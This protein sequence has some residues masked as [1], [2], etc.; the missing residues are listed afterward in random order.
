MKRSALFFAIFNLVALLCCGQDPPVIHAVTLQDTVVEQY[1]KLEAVVDLGATYTNPYDYDQIVVSA[2][3]TGPTGE[4]TAVDGFFMKD[5][6]I[7]P[8]TGALIPVG[9]GGKFKVRFSPGQP[10]EWSFVVSVSDV[11]G[12][13]TYPPVSFEC[14]PD[15]NARGFV[16]RNETNYLHFDNGE[17]YI[18][19]GE[20]MAWQNGNAYLNYTE[21]LSNLY[22]NGGNYIRL[23]QAHWGLGIE[24]KNGVNGFEGL[25]RYK[26]T[27]MRYQDW[28]FDYCAENGVYVMNC[29]QHHGQVS[30]QVNPNW[31]ESPYN[32]ANGGPCANTWDFFTNVQARAHTLNRFRYTVARWGYARSILCWELFNEVEWTDNFAQHKAEVAA[33]HAEMAAWFKANDPYQHLVTTSYAQDQY[34]P[35]VWSMP[36]ID[37]TQTHFYINSSNLERALVNG[38]RNYL[39]DYQKPTLT[40]EFG[41]GVTSDLTV[42]DA[43]GIHIHNA[44]WGTLFGGGMGS[45]NT[46]WWDNYIHPADLYYHFAPVAAVA[47]KIPF[48]NENMK[49]ADVHVSG[50]PG[51]LKFTP[52]L[53][54]GVIGEDQISI[55]ENGVVTPSNPGLGLYLYGSLWNTQYRS[56]PTFTAYYPEAGHFT[57]KTGAD[58]STSP[59]IA[60]YRDGILILE[61]AGT[62]NTA[63]TITVPAGE[64]QIKVDNTGT[65]WI[66]ISYYSL[67]GLGSKIDAYVLL[68]ENK[69]VAAGWVLNNEFNHQYLAEHGE[70]APASGGQLALEGFLDG[71]YAVF[72]YHGLSGVNIYS[73]AVYAEAGVL[74][75]PVPTL[76]W[77]LAFLV[78]SDPVGTKEAV[79]PLAFQVSPNPAKPGAEVRL[80]LP[81]DLRSAKISLLEMGGRAL[82]E[83]ESREELILPADLAPGVYWIA[84]ERDGAWGAVPIVIQK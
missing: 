45:G 63:Y 4:E 74:T 84:V 25:R 48:L 50:S 77:D 20:C 46:W 53:G 64:H 18:P 1:G 36:D 58:L 35:E 33:W 80:S 27:N 52:T 57:V 76:Y 68:S 43:D 29:L 59:K 51:D 41:L 81:G 39:D 8:A 62:A 69:N 15:S 7:N 17:Q 38:I 75:L 28:L 30:S 32:A 56:P 47:S 6:D 82:K 34:D 55:D 26:E 14:V 19:V 44:L 70:P 83:F 3:F 67:S 49:P 71:E 12:D 5:F 66:T 40:G 54:W 16:R 78:N 65:D 31:Y 72:W 79:Q 13:A 2:V 23:W 42:T 24:W 9:S 10:G 11:N 73:E 22:G 37:F 21:W 61:Q 60:I